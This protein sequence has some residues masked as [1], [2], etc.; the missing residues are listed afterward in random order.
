MDNKYLI[1][2]NK[3]NS[4]KDENIYEKVDCKSPYADG[5]VLEK[6]TFESFLKLRNFIKEQGYIIE[7]SNEYS[8][9]G[10]KYS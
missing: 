9:I 5:R 2:V 6:E 1:L 7:M 8:S 3:D 10:R 4:L